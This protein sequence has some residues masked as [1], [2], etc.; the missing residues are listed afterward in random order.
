MVTAREERKT[1]LIPVLIFSGKVEESRRESSEN[2][3]KLGFK[4]W[5]LKAAA[6][7]VVAVIK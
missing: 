7:P 5:K 4:E 3:G 1:A 2:A 6:K